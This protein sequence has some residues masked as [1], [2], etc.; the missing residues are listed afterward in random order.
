MVKNLPANA[1]DT[2]SIPGSGRSLGGEN[3]NPPQCSCLENPMDRGTWR[4][5]IHGGGR[6]GRDLATEHTHTSPW[7]VYATFCLSI[8]SSHNGHLGYFHLLPSVNNAAVNTGVQISRPCFQ[9]PWVYNQ[10]WNSRI[11]WQFYF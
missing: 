1:G 7:Y 2:G 5:S 10:K 6:V 9:F 4:A 11:I 8:H 3:G